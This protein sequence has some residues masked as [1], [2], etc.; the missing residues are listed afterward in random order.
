MKNSVLHIEE[1]LT[2]IL[3]SGSPILSASRVW[4]DS[5]PVFWSLAALVSLPES[6]EGSLPV[7]WSLA[8][9]VSL[10]EIMEGSLPV[11]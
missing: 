4:K 11:I 6:M 5:L 1:I 8:A 10:P 3:T 2:C 7:I 9:L